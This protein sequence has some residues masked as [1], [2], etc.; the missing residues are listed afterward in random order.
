MIDELRSAI[1]IAQ[2]QAKVFKKYCTNE[3]HICPLSNSCDWDNTIDL[4]DPSLTDEKLKAFVDLYEDITGRRERD[5]FK[6]ATGIDPAWYD[7]NEDRSED[8]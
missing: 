6:T 5:N 7:F 3:C 2:E 8:R 4:T 1:T